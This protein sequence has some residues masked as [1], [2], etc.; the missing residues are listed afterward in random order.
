MKKSKITYKKIINHPTCD[1]IYYLI[2]TRFVS[3]YIT[4]KLINTKISA[5]HI[6]Y[7]MILSGITALY[8]LF[9]NDSKMLI[10]ASLFFIFHNILDTVDGDLARENKTISIFGNFLDK[11]TH[12]IINPG[13]FLCLHYKYKT[14][15]PIISELFLIT[16][17]VILSD[18]ILKGHFD[19]ITKKKYSFLVSKNK[20]KNL[21]KKNIIK[22]IFSIF[23]STVGFFHILLL[24]SI[25]DYLFEKNVTMFYL[26][27]LAIITIIKFFIR[28]KI[29]FK[30]I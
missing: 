15:T 10:V 8:F 6:S 9:F 4:S 1:E 14:I 12:V 2:F 11:F 16:S 25:L 27:F 7:L 26:I 19:Y 13:I 22:K 24:T 28:L 5:N 29:M 23:F 21:I 20:S 30:L 18:T 3:A 17:I